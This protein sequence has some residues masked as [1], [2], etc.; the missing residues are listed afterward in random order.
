MDAHRKILGAI[1]RG[2]P[3]EAAESMRLHLVSSRR[4][5]VDLQKKG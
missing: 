5:F 1:E 2:K 4:H 3:D